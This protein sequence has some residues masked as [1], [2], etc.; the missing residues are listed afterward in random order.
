MPAGL[1]SVLGHLYPL[2]GAEPAEVINGYTSLVPRGLG[3]LLCLTDTGYT[4]PEAAARV[5]ERDAKTG[6]RYI[7]LFGVSQVMVQRGPLLDA[8]EQARSPDWVP[9]SESPWWVMYGNGTRL[10]ENPVVWASDGV[11]VDGDR[12]IVPAGGQVVL[13]RPLWPGTEVSVGAVRADLDPVADIF[14]R[15]TFDEDVSGALQIHQRVPG[16]WAAAA[17]AV[18]GALGLLACAVAA[19]TASVRR[20]TALGDR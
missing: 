18:V 16:A 14:V 15:A 12:L 7:D 4:C 6:L 19:A 17:A 11:T 2:Y 8:F 1:P 3:R 10:G 13:S 20:R 9:T 5:F